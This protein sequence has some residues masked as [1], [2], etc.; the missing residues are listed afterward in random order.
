MKPENLKLHLILA[1]SANNTIGNGQ[2]IPWSVKGEQVIF[3]A[4][5]QF[6][7]CIVGRKTYETVSHLADRKFIVLSRKND[8]S[9]E[10]DDVRVSSIEEAFEF[11][12]ENE[13]KLAYVCGGGDIYRQF[14]PYSDYLH[15]SELQAACAGD[16]KSPNFA[17]SIYE[18]VM[19][20]PYQSNIDFVYRLYRRK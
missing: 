13:I 5:T 9:L 12:K 7:W 10:G 6:Q 15:I 16:V 8:F 17:L 2:D 18:L 14:A 11:L 4:M 3:K 20:Q 19:E 1:Q